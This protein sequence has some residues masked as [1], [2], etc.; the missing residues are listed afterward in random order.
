ML[1]SSRGNIPWL[2]QGYRP[3]C[4]IGR[5]PTLT[6]SPTGTIEASPKRNP[7][8]QAGTLT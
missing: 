2:T 7:K 6:S 3:A 5:T 1:K 8:T 4:A